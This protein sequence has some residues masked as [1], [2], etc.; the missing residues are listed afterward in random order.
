MAHVLLGALSRIGHLVG[1]SGERVL[2]SGIGCVYHELATMRQVVASGR[3]F[4]QLLY[5]P[6]GVKLP[7]SGSYHAVVILV[8]FVVVVLA[9]VRHRC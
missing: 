6:L 4:V 7:T 8:V 1:T 2:R 3:I 9:V 5:P